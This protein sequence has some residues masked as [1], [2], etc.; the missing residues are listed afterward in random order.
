MPPECSSLR[1]GANAISRSH[2][3]VNNL[4]RAMGDT[5]AIVLPVF[6][7]IGLGTLFAWT[8]LLGH[9]SGDALSDFVFVVAIPFLIFQIV[10]TADFSGLSAWRLW[11]A[12][13]AAFAMIWAAGTLLMGRLFERDARGGL[14]GGLAAGY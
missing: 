11:L 10:A 5:L 9:A 3:H 14:V 6:G 1:R 2:R 7:L 13:F 12:F 8:K 4:R